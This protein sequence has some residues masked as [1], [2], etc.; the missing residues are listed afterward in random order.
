MKIRLIIAILAGGSA[1]GL[2]AA[3]ASLDTAGPLGETAQPVARPSVE[4][5]GSGDG[6]RPTAALPLAAPTIRYDRR[7]GVE[8]QFVDADVRRIIDAVMGDVLRLSYTVDPAVSG[9]M[10]LRTAQPVAKTSVLS[11][12]ENALA[13]IGVAIV[14]QGEAYSVVPIANARSQVTAPA[15]AGAA[16]FGNETITLRYGSAQEI[17]RVL[18]GVIKREGAVVPDFERNQLTFVGTA[19]D[20]AALRRV[21]ASLDVDWLSGS[22]FAFYTLDTIDPETLVSDL[23]AIFKPPI[24]ILE[25]RVRLIPFPRLKAVLGVARNRADLVRLEPWIRR[26]DA[27][28]GGKRRLY[29]YPIKNGLARDIAG[30]LQD[31]L[32][33]LLVVPGGG[34]G[35][36]DGDPGNGA[37]RAGDPGFS[38]FARG[39][40]S[41]AG[42][43]GGST[44]PPSQQASS[45]APRTVPAA[46]DSARIVPDDANNNLLI[47]ADG[48]E[49]QTIRDA[50]DKVD[51]IPQQ[52]LIE[53]VLAEVTL[54]NDLDLGLQWFFQTDGGGNQFRLSGQPDGSVASQFPG[55]S[56]TYAGIANARVVLNALQSRTNVRVLSTP[57]LMVLNNQTATLQVGDQVPIV[58]QTSQGV[59]A[60]GAPVI[61]TVELRDTGVILRVT[62]RVS[63]QGLVRL[64]I[65][66]EV[67]D[68][69]ETTTSGINSPTIRQRRLTT[70]VAAPTGQMIALGGLIR[71]IQSRGSAG[72]PL[73]SDIPVL[74]QLFR[75]NSDSA[76]RTELIILLTPIVIRDPRDAEASVNELVANMRN[77]RALVDRLRLGETD[78]TSR[79]R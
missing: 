11:A 38:G 5:F 62:P 66:Q 30:A 33:G 46:P 27:G 45:S 26:L 60:P 32:S 63:D 22:A 17:A 74:G 51:I 7:R 47:F 20:R 14:R 2:A 18:A 69:V 8:L 78:A 65:A 24:A 67:S 56:Y 72:I 49:Y 77:A 31:V 15:A 54:G 1:A 6:D 79:P 50:L 13:S 4:Y 53:A 16:G 12:L 21:V 3:P 25:T 71:D 70:T 76:T 44:L 40:P 36:G 37:V 34:A 73:L 29:V 55:F 52:I 58:T 10:T 48:E 64:E 43:L 23:Q 57:K 41:G 68:V 39:G 59:L 61:N 19:A 42:G 75:T 9:T 28:V 35:G